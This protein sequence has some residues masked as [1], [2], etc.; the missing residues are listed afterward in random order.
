[1]TTPGQP[2]HYVDKVLKLSESRRSCSAMS[3][4]RLRGVLT[5]S[6]DPVAN[7]FCLGHIM[8]GQED[9]ASLGAQLRDQLAELAG[10]NLTCDFE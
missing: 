7:G 9:R 3:L 10:G 8:R 2:A 5:A 6:S 4:P 1:M